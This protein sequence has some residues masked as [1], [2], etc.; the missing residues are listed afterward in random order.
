MCETLRTAARGGTAWAVW[1]GRA[2]R[3]PCIIVD[4]GYM[5]DKK[6]RQR[7]IKKIVFVWLIAG[8]DAGVFHLATE[9]S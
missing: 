2:S 6:Q 7:A 5:A 8:I 3:G 9:R 4:I 1:R